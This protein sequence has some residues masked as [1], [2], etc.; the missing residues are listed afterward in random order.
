MDADTYVIREIAVINTENA[1]DSHKRENQLGEK[2][3][4]SS[5]N[6][7]VREGIAS[8]IEYLVVNSNFVIRSVRL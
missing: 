6:I 8:N 1:A 7:Y 3:I 5:V 2:E 4:K